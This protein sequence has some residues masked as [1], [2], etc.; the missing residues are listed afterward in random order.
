MTT[1]QIIA[2]ALV[3]GVFIWSYLPNIKDLLKNVP[4]VNPI[5]EGLPP[6]P[7]LMGQIEDVVKIRQAHAAENVTKACNHLLEVLLQVKP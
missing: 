7:D 6:K 2:I 5:D 3:A 4:I 1:Q